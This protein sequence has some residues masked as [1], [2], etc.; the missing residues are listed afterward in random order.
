M[1]NRFHERNQ[2]MTVNTI[3]STLDEI[4]NDILEMVSE[5]GMDR[6]YFQSIHS[7]IKQYMG[8]T[9]AT[10]FLIMFI[11]RKESTGLMMRMT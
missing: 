7:Q 1:K 2:S 9:C 8:P 4:F 11:V 3:M 6:T 10:I 5:K